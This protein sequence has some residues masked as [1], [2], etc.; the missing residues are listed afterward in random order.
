MTRYAFRDFV[1]KYPFVFCAIKQF[2]IKTR[3]G[4]ES[5]KSER[6]SRPIRSRKGGI[7][8]LNWKSNYST[9]TVPSGETET[10][11]PS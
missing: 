4:H 7:G 9:V 5:G 6:K 1:F 11:M 2:G 3:I 10:V 8:R